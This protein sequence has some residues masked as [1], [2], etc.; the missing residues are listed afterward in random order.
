[1]K[2]LRCIPLA[3]LLAGLAWASQALPAAQAMP[4]RPPTPP[5]TG[6]LSLQAVQPPAG[7]WAGVEWQTAA[8]AWLPVAGW[9]GALSADGRQQWRALS[10]QANTGPYRWTIYTRAGGAVWAR[11]ASFD[12]PDLGK[13]VHL[14]VSAQAQPAAAGGT[15]YVLAHEPA[16]S[17]G[18][19]R[20]G[21][22]RVAGQF[23]PA[24]SVLG[25]GA[26]RVRILTPANGPVY[27]IPAQTTAPGSFSV[28]LPRP[29]AAGAYEVQ[30]FRLNGQPA[31]APVSLDVRA[32]CSRNL[33]GL[34][35]AA[36]AP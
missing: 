28:V 10:D 13:E 20:C 19:L 22:V 21:L 17:A 23:Q 2:L 9:Q 26:V 30:V 5:P 33:I 3:L 36:E 11:S 14:T 25:R 4:P 27:V 35:F 32:D 29:L 15:A 1:M 34:A 18:S 7:A 12:L 24:E 31:S 16:Y 6:L 8:G